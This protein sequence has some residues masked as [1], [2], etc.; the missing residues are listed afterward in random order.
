[1]S[2]TR[3]A[4]VMWNSSAEGMNVT[5]E[6]RIVFGEGNATVGFGE[7]VD[8]G[9]GVYVYKDPENLF[10]IDSMTDVACSDLDE[11]ITIGK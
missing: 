6:L 10:Y 8:R 3:T 9:D 1:M 2:M 7:M 5:E 4:N 11:K